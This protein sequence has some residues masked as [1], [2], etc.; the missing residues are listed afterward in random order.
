MQAKGGCY[1]GAVRYEI[2]GDPIFQAQCHCRECQ[3]YSGGQPNMVIG[4]AADHF[5]LVSGDLASFTRTD[6]DNPATREFCKT[7]GVSMWTKVASM[8]GAH[9]I[10]AG[11]LDDPAVFGPAQMAIFMCDAQAYHPKPDGLP[12][13]DK[14]PG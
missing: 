10:K 8:P 3:Y 11:T 4:V 2:D 13:F 6:I 5:T 14:V 12:A 1:C 9:L 7:C